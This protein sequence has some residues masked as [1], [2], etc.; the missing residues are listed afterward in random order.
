VRTALTGTGHV[1][2]GVESLIEWVLGIV[3]HDIP[4]F[5]KHSLIISSYRGQT[6]YPRIFETNFIER[7]SLLVMTGAPGALR[8]DGQIYNKGVSREREPVSIHGSPPEVMSKLSGETVNVP[9]SPFRDLSIKWEV[10]KGDKLLYISL[11]S[12]YSRGSF[13]PFP[14]L[15]GAIHSLYVQECPHARNA[16]L[17]ESDEFVNY[18][19]PFSPWGEIRP[20]QSKVGVIPAH[21]NEGVRMLCLVHGVPGVVQKNACLQCSLDVCRKAGFR[22]VIDARQYD[23]P[24][25]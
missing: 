3:G 4:P 25:D 24:R 13:N 21:G 5:G 18:T 6:F 16:T 8:Y 7:S 12:S 20:E 10:S 19:S 17:L 2:C 1:T 23:W 22:F 14:I 11:V 15:F 9:C